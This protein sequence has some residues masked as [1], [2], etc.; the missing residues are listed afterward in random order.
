[1]DLH[2]FARWHG[3]GTPRSESWHA[4]GRS[5]RK[6]FADFDPGVR[7]GALFDGQEEISTALPV[8]PV[9]AIGEFGPDFALSQCHGEKEGNVYSIDFL[10]SYGVIRSRFFP[11]TV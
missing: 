6:N 9:T 5:V 3:W 7:F 10:F 1:M 4:T 8:T 2:G 11:V